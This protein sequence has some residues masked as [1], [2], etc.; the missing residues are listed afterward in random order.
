MLKGG[1]EVVVVDHE[2]LLASVVKVRKR[3]TTAEIWTV[4]EALVMP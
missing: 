4:S 2:G 1:L 3:G